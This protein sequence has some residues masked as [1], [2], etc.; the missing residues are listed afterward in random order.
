[1]SMFNMSPEFEA[2]LKRLGIN[3]E[4]EVKDVENST[5]NNKQNEGKNVKKNMP[6]AGEKRRRGRPS[7]TRKNA[8]EEVR[9]TFTTVTL[10]ADVVKSLRIYH[11]VFSILEGKV[12]FGDFLLDAVRL[13]VSKECR[14]ADEIMSSLED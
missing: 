6:K 5:E 7:G 4:E 2:E 3:P 8:P 10:N 11:T 14:K 13:Y 9:S 1:M 12:S